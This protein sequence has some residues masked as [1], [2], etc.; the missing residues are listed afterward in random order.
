MV[1]EIANLRKADKSIL[2][3][4]V[5]DLEIPVLNL[6]PVTITIFIQEFR[7]ETQQNTTIIRFHCTLIFAGFANLF[8]C[9]A[10]LR[11]FLRIH[12]KDIH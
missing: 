8:C 9:L 1:R 4:I 6:D 12:F 7:L 10:L 5:L 2:F 11:R 3:Q